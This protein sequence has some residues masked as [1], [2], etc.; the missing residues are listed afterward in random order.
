MLGPVHAIK[1]CLA[2]SFQLSGRASRSEFWWFAPLPVLIAIAAIALADVSP[3]FANPAVLYPL[4]FV[5]FPTLSFVLI[6]AGTRRL[7][8]AGSAYSR[9]FQAALL[10]VLFLYVVCGGTGIFLEQFAGFST[11]SLMMLGIVA[12]YFCLPVA[13]LILLCFAFPLAAPSQPG[14]NRY[15]PNPLEVTP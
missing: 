7:I 13:T 4:L 14:P 12:I 8:D 1:T 3:L 5:L 10:F 11:E 15:G 9:I 6:A 2:K